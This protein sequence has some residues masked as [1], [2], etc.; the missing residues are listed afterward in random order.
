MNNMQVIVSCIFEDCKDVG[1]EYL[2][3]T[4]DNF[5]DEEIVKEIPVVGTVITLLKLPFSLGNAYYM[6]KILKFCYHMKSIPDIKRRRFV[7]KAINQDKHFGEKLLI[8]LDKMD[9][10]DK[11]EMLVKVFRAYGHDE[12]ISYNDFRRLS[13]IIIN[14][15]VE[16]LNYIKLIY[17]KKYFGGYS[18]I[19]LVSNGLAREAIYDEISENDTD[20]RYSLTSIG[21][22][23]YECVFTDKYKID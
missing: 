18:A 7:K 10:L 2:E 17:D 8:T 4:I 1:K 13:I 16:D 3:M 23:F 9:D 6:Q 15:F 11:T 14:T 19:P 22:L 21:R 5:S 12:G 20:E